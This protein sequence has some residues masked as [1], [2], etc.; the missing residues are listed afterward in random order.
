MLKQKKSM[1]TTL[2]KDKFSYFALLFL[3]SMP[4]AKADDAVFLL[5]KV[6]A[7]VDQQVILHSELEE[8]YKQANLESKTLDASHKK[9]LLHEL[10][11]SKFFLAKAKSN[12]LK[13]PQ[14]Y[15][16]KECNLTITSWMQHLGSEEALTKY[17]QQPLHLIRKDLKHSLKEKYLIMSVQQ[18]LT[19][20]IIVKPTEVEAYFHNLPKNKRA[21]YP[22][23]FELD[24]LIIYPKVASTR[25]EAIKQQL[26][27][28]KKKLVAGKVSFSQ[29]AQEYSDDP[30][31]KRK[32][33]DIGWFP[34]GVLDPNYESTALELPI[35][36]V[37][38]PVESQFGFH[39]IELMERSK[40]GYH[41]RHILKLLQ[42]NSEEI[43]FAEEHLNQIRLD[44]IAGKL[45][46]E[47]ALKQNTE[48][49]S[50][51]P[52]AHIMMNKKQNRSPFSSR[53]IAAD[54]LDPTVYFAIYKL[55]PGEV[56]TLQF[57]GE[58]INP[59]WRL[60]YLKQK[61]DAHEMNLEQDYEQMHDYLLEQ[62][63]QKA[64][65]EWFQKAKSIFVVDVASEY[66]E[67]LQWL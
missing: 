60:F 14:E 10:I 57:V 5:D 58:Q 67:V 59:A 39:L 54:D 30:V 41:T 61:I 26:I 62:K 64:I 7:T 25:K 37:S 49:E 24:Q 51:M 13:I 20:N 65:H 11:L 15:I 19:E 53:F 45:S 55:K 17:F 44:I 16:E 34:F 6:I 3:C 36:R 18:S 27:D 12:D 63:K 22:T 43:R 9:K 33:G 35:G 31:S 21:F 56:S 38:D 32:G 40:E 8:M 50:G 47:E 46:F 4:F 52:R 28:C 42:P 66:K 2:L 48:K 23:A 29:L 1:L